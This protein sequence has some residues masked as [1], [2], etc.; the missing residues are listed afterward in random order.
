MILN[1]NKSKLQGSSNAKLLTIK[2]LFFLHV[3]DVNATLY[4]IIIVY[5]EVIFFFK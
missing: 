3:R 4:G 1:Y 2:P 5:N